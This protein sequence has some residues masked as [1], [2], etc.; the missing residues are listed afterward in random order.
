M[1][2]RSVCI[3]SLGSVGSSVEIGALLISGLS[4]INNSG[5]VRIYQWSATSATTGSWEQK[6]EDIDGEAI[7]DISGGSGS[8]S[9]DVS[10]VAIGV[11]SNSS[12]CG[13]VRSDLWNETPDKTGSLDI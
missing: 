10:T 5:H 2:D 11:L 4:G 12:Y 1:S 13:H 6:G 9:S 8:F 7:S 3:V